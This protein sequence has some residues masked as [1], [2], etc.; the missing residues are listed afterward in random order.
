MSSDQSDSCWLRQVKVGDRACIPE[1]WHKY[2]QRMV[3]LARQ[4]LGGVP[5]RVADE[6][7]VALSAF[8]S[9]CRGAE[10]GR[11][12]RL[13]D[14]EDIWQLLVVLTIRKACDLIQYLRRQGRDFTREDPLPA[15]GPD[16]SSE[17]A[18]LLDQLIGREPDPALETAVIE[19][20]QYL[21]D[22]LGQ[23]QVRD[24]AVYKIE[25][26]TNQEIA[27]RLGC[28]LATVERR[29]KLIREHWRKELDT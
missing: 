5:R 6:E 22:K 13:E 2:F 28:S 1:L 11:F 26:Y 10:E 21:L 19:E 18:Q 29:V 14:R 16:T 8:D 4:K 23:G 3:G 7:D 20:W 27:D 24:V 25:G 15:V 9:F 12:P 17:D